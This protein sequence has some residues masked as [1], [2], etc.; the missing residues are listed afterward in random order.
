MALLRCPQCLGPV[1][2]LAKQ[3]PR[4]AVQ[5]QVAWPSYLTSST[6]APIALAPAVRPSIPRQ[7]LPWWS[8]I[9]AVFTS[10]PFLILT[11]FFVAVS[12]PVLALFIA[13]EGLAPV[14]RRQAGYVLIIAWS[15]ALGLYVMR[16][17]GNITPQRIGSLLADLASFTR[18]ELESLLDVAPAALRYFGWC[19]FT[20]VTAILAIVLYGL[21]SRHV[22]GPLPFLTEC[23]PIVISAALFTT[24]HVGWKPFWR[25]MSGDSSRQ[26]KNHSLLWVSVVFMAWLVLMLILHLWRLHQIAS[27]QQPGTLGP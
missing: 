4:C 14:D 25:L 11:T 2:N 23:F 19:L 18:F 10:L 17:R 9:G 7:S 1:S 26:E 22:F 6:V 20:F 12:T 13:D 21:M 5:V 27:W 24:W 8:H 15:G 16:Y 3:C